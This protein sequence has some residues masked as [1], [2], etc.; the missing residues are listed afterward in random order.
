MMQLCILGFFC[1]TLLKVFTLRKDREKLPW[2][3]GEAP[4]NSSLLIQAVS[5][6]NREVVVE[7]LDAKADVTNVRKNKNKIR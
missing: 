1:F 7:L 6:Q 2:I 5:S 3:Y 4:S